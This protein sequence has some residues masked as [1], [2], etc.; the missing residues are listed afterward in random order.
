MGIK[1]SQ[2]SKIEPA[3][4]EILCKQYCVRRNCGQ[5]AST[6][7]YDCLI[8]YTDMYICK[9]W[10]VLYILLQQAVAPPYSPRVDLFLSTGRSNQAGQAY[11]EDLRHGCQSSDCVMN[12]AELGVAF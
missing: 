12:S 9:E 2:I 8:P 3:P 4:E 1:T 10:Q 5:G 6:F 7:R 11:P